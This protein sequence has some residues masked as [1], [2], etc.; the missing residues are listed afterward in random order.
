MVDPEIQDMEKRIEALYGYL[1]PYKPRKGKGWVYFIQAVTGGPIKIGWSLRPVDRVRDLQGA[2]PHELTIVT[3]F[4]GSVAMERRLHRKFAD[5]RL[6]GEWF[7]DC[8][9]I[10]AEINARGLF[11]APDWEIE[12]ACK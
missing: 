10:Q 12:N 5:F 8:P 11:T 2:H 4:R 7:E 3:M 6:L 9:E 1:K